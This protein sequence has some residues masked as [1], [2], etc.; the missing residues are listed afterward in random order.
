[1]AS[2]SWPNPGMR[3][4]LNRISGVIIVASAFLV[5]APVTFSQ[6]APRDKKFE[7]PGC[8][9]RVWIEYTDDDPDY[10]IIKN[11]SPKGWTL[12]ALAI[13][14]LPSMG[15]LVFD[16]DE[17]GKGVGGAALLPRCNFT[18]TS[19]RH[20]PGPRWWAYNRIAI[21]RLSKG[22]GLH[23]SCGP[24][25]AIPSEGGRTWVL[26][27][28]VKGA[29]VMATFKGPSGQSDKIDAIFD[30]NAEADSGSRGCV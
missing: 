19:H 1:M 13:D 20:G 24:R 16:T 8:G 10:F 18:C 5:S 28:D 4:T 30:E 7:T 15:N 22:P 25:R 9:P 3:S 2:L 17:G 12:E 21:Q 29:K 11:R 27:S 23:L 26:P 14:L 6:T